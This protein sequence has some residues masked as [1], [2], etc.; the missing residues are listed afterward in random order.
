MG[1]DLKGTRARVIAEYL[2]R[3]KKVWWSKVRA[4]HSDQYCVVMYVP[5][6]NE[7]S[8]KNPDPQLMGGCGNAIF[9]WSHE[10]EKTAHARPR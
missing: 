6:S 2:R 10:V 4:S 9:L 5:N 7:L 8:C 1:A 3:V